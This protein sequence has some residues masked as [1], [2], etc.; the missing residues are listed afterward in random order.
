LENTTCWFNILY[1]V[2]K[3]KGA[4]DVVARSA[5][6]HMPYSGYYDYSPTQLARLKQSLLSLRKAAPNKRIIAFTIP[7]ANDWR[8]YGSSK[9]FPGLP[10]E[11]DQFCK[12]NNIF[13]TDLLTTGSIDDQQNYKKQFF[14]CGDVHWNEYGN[15]WAMKK[16]LPY[17]ISNK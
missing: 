16:L 4:V 14:D 13:Y 8:R 10:L 11:L 17:F 2:I 9:A 6:A 15:R 3:K 12:T 5:R 7:I 1:F